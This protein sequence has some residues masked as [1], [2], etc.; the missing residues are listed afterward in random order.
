M[1][2]Q[3]IGFF[4]LVNHNGMW[5]KIYSVIEL[6]VLEL[7]SPLLSITIEVVPIPEAANQG[8]DAK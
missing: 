7:P 4:E 1:T 3:D 6:T 5:L 8:N 2:T